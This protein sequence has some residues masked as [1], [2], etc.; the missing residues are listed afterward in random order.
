MIIIIT[1]IAKPP[2]TK[3]SFVNSRRLPACPPVR[4]CLPPTCLLRWVHPSTSES[5]EFRYLGILSFSLSIHVLD[6]IIYAIDLNFGLHV[7]IYIYIHTQR[8]V[9]LS[10]YISIYIYTYIYIYIY[11]Y[12]QSTAAGKKAFKNIS[13]WTKACQA[14]KKAGLKS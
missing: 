9:S 4:L 14:A 13:G 12:I 10:L 7:P 8:Y 11:I 6:S 5:L 1:Q 2:F 3:P